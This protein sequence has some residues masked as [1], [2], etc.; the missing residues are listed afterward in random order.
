MQSLIEEWR[1]AWATPDF[2]FAMVQLAAY[3]SSGADINAIRIAQA[4]ATNRTANTGMALAID[5][6]DPGAPL[7]PVHS[8][9]KEPVAARLAATMYR[10]RG[11]VS[12][13][14]ATATAAATDSCQ[15]PICAAHAE[16]SVLPS[17]QILRANGPELTSSTLLSF[18]ASNNVSTVELR[19]DYA[20]GLRFANTS[21][22]NISQPVGGS[23]RGLRRRCCAALPDTMHLCLGGAAADNAPYDLNASACFGV[24]HI[25]ADAATGTVR[26]AS[27]S[28]PGPAVWV[29][30]SA[31]PYPECALFNDAGLPASPFAAELTKAEPAA[32]A[33]VVVRDK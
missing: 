25:T 26:M 10:L 11:C 5:R 2:P 21:L 29:R 17:G 1:A 27:A 28:M 13:C 3:Y 14:A 6:G 23:S 12:D 16:G 20:A 4:V 32:A 15:L 19:F 9:D 30:W 7:G 24:E 8:R 18:T 22:C 31:D 33:A